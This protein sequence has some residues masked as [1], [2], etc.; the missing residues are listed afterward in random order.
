MQNKIILILILI[1]A[2]YLRFGGAKPGFPPYHSDEG[3]S[4]SAATSMIKNGNLD[5]LRYDYP[6]LV[7]DINYIFFR[8]IFIPLNWTKYYISHIPEILDGIVHIPIAPLEEKKLFQT[9]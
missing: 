4:Y 7:P 6:S 9:Y 1:L 5:P 8:L 2:S 3:I